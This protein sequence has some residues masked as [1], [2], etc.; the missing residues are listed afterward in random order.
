MF[1]MLG[2]LAGMFSLT[3]LIWK[4][5]QFSVGPLMQAV[6]QSY[7]DE[8]RQFFSLFEPF[9]LNRLE[10][11]H[12]QFGWEVHL[13]PHW[14]HAFVLLWLYF[15]AVARSYWPDAKGT[16]AA[17]VIWGALVAF[18]AAGLVGIIAPG[19]ELFETCIVLVPTIA[20]LIFSFGTAAWTS[21]F[22]RD[23]LRNNYVSDDPL[24]D[25]IEDITRVRLFVDQTYYAFVYFG[26]PG[27][28]ASLITYNSEFIPLLKDAES[29]GLA[30]LVFLTLSVAVMYAIDPI[31]H[32][33]EKLSS[34]E[35]WIDNYRN[36]RGV[37][38]GLSMLSVVG[39]SIFFAILGLAGV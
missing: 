1:R 11:L 6:L 35:S 15:G 18:V 28:I 14:K 20:Y 17:F 31:I 38:I 27:A 24:T 26:V 23:M 19:D 7:E 5:F 22:L 2:I 13:Y 9:L 39:G 12:E 37:L 36:S 21:V 33:V 8:A 25:N 4:G 34:E 3:I 29:P 10:T 32:P 30:V 16:S